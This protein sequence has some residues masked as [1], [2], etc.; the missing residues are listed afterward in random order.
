MIIT[1]IALMWRKYPLKCLSQS[2]N[3]LSNNNNSNS[4]FSSQQLPSY[5]WVKWKKRRPCLSLSLSLLCLV[6]LE[7][8][9]GTSEGV[10]PSTAISARGPL[11][12]DYLC[13][14]CSKRIQHQCTMSHLPIPS[15]SWTFSKYASNIFYCLKLRYIYFLA[16]RND[17]NMHQLLTKTVAR[18]LNGIFARF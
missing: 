2:L 17:P 7:R 5:T 16:Q 6:L 4:Y 11:Q 14:A 15:N 18:I 10:S 3:I 8:T 9:T 12:K 13:L 1:D